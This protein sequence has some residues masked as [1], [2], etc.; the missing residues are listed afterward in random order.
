MGSQWDTH[1][2]EFP[3]G[4]SQRADVMQESS[5]MTTRSE[6]RQSLGSLASDEIVF[7]PKTFKGHSSPKKDPP[8]PEPKG[9]D[10]EA[11]EV[12]KENVNLEK[13]TRRRSRTK[14]EVLKM[15]GSEVTTAS[16]PARRKHAKKLSSGNAPYSYSCTLNESHQSSVYGVMFNPYLPCD[17]EYYMA[18]CGSNQVNV[19][20]LTDDGKK[21][22]HVV[23]LIDSNKEECFYALT[24]AID[25]IIRTF[26]L[27]VG[28]AKGIIRVIDP[29]AKK[30][31]STLRGHGESV[32]EIRTS[33]MNSMIVASAS[34]DRTAR[35]WNVA[36][37]NCLAIYGGSEGHLDEVIS[38]D[39]H[40][41]QDFL[42]TASMDHTIRV[43]DLRP[44]TEVGKRIQESVDPSKHESFATLPSIENHFSLAVAKDVHTNYVDCARF[45]G[46]F[47]IS[48]SC[49]NQIVLW[50]FGGFD[51]PVSGQGTLLR[52]ETYVLHTAWVE[53]PKSSIWFIK[54]DIDP[55][56]KY[57][58]V[59]NEEGTVKLVD[60]HSIKP[61]AK[62]PDYAL[63][64][65]ETGRVC[66]RQTA[67]SPD[68][69][70]LVSSGEGGV[71]V[72]YD[73]K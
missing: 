25:E 10:W 22:E 26:V 12:G 49:E 2:S 3:D 20:R 53:V 44:E 9:D 62:K 18:T 58:A 66:V 55:D 4:P 30:T 56:N 11:L 31:I 24:W 27:V 51:Q 42:L 46:N 43:W 1:S 29:M 13:A 65:P 60:L 15:G 41:T 34:K 52:T 40:H 50:R 38:L 54:F 19:Y 67:F 5:A 33:P 48:K 73:R 16:K 57:L 8:T 63:S 69:K 68:G 64:C 37:Q 47:I 39:F 23:Q 6:S 45:Y 28:G 14:K 32:N 35:V 61:E 21:P 72:R 17:E 71:I 36:L 70:V 59:G 7:H